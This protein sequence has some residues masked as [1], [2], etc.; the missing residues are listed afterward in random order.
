MPVC[1]VCVRVSVCMFVCACVYIYMSLTALEV[2]LDRVRHPPLQ[3]QG[4]HV[5]A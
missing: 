1:M 2:P 5:R 4:D 3:L